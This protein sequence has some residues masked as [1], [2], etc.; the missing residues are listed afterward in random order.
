MN[1]IEQMLTGQIHISDFVKHLNT[2]EHIREIIRGLV[3]E[4]AIHDDSHAFWGNIS[5][6]ILRKFDF[7]YLSLLLGS[8]RFDG[9]LGDN[10]NIFSIVGQAYHYYA[11]QLDYTTYYK[12]AFCLYLEAVGEYYEGPE[13]TPIL[14]QIV[15]DVLSIK[16]KSQ[17]IKKIRIK[18][19]EEFHIDGTKRPYWIQG[20]EWPMGKYSPM[21][22]IGRS[23]I[24]NGAQYI[25]QDV[26]T[27]ETHVVK[28]YY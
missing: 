1:A 25:F 22:Y 21:Q 18:L 13:V 6:D 8:C 7:N 17:R 15:T 14:N 16:S 27:G 9:T 24:P 23:K 12:D 4:E 28:Q 5:R 10:L 11:P 3:P 26:D 19:K 2:D 20:G